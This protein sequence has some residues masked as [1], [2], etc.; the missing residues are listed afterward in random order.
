MLLKRSGLYA[1]GM[2]YVACSTTKLFKTQS[3]VWKCFIKHSD[4]ID[5]C[6]TILGCG[7]S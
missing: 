6:H 2:F 3:V 7:V 5:D 4:D 1:F